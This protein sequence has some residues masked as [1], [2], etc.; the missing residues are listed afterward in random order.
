MKIV[1]AFGQEG[2]EAA[3][4][5]TT[6]EAGFATARRRIALRAAMTAN[7]IALALGSITAVSWRGALDVT[8]RRLSGGRISSLL[9]TGRPG[10]GPVRRQSGT[11]GGPS[12]G[13]RKGS[14][15]GEGET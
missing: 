8:A 5:D 7:G 3:R 15:G 10:A 12:P 14:A 6:V 2:R 13:D 11:R 4:F 9:L 1:Q